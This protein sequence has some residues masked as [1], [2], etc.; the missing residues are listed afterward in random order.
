MYIHLDLDVIDPNDFPYVTCPTHN[1]IRIEKL[2]DLIDL[3][4]KDFDVVGCSVLEFLP[5]EPKKKA[6]LAVAKLL[7]EI[8]LRP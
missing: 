7:D 8:G 6:T 2:Q 3:L 5:T 4:S 1:G